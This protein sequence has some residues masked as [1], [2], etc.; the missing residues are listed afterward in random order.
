MKAVKR[1]YMI[2]MSLM[3]G[4]DVAGAA[5][6]PPQN[7]KVLMNGGPPHST[8]QETF[9][10]T[11]NNVKTFS[12]KLDEFYLVVNGMYVEHKW[13]STEMSVEFTEL[14]R[15]Y[16]EATKSSTKL[17]A[18][19][20]A[21]LEPT[22]TALSAHLRPVLGDL[23]LFID[24]IHHSIDSHS[25]YLRGLVYPE[26]PE[27]PK[28]ATEQPG[29]GEHY[30]IDMFDHLTDRDGN[31]F[32]GISVSTDT[33]YQILNSP[34]KPATPITNEKIIATDVVLVEAPAKRCCEDSAHKCLDELVPT[35]FSDVHA[36]VSQIE[37]VTF[38]RKDILRTMANQKKTFAAMFG[39]INV[40][41]IKNGQE[42]DCLADELLSS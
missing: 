16:S 36:L 20:T 7:A 39:D 12:A 2:N 23:Q 3:S 34:M 1:D 11:Q 4:Y 10:K 30:D 22:G 33:S 31:M 32:N 25:E 15:K 18:S 17:R 40:Q 42:I 21:F 37:L 27:H 28:H 5:T 35:N 13:N 14:L 8:P 26:H 19:G 41:L 6:G 29:D 9:I 24:R 38:R